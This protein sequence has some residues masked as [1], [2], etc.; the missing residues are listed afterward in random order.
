MS[1]V[2][3]ERVAAARASV[4]GTRRTRQRR[5]VVVSAVLVVLVAAAFVGSVLYGTRTVSLGEV[6]E[7][8]GGGGTRA[9]YYL[10]VELRL[11]RALTGLLVGLC[12]G[13]AGALFQTLLRNPL[14]SPDV[15]GI[16][17]GASAAAVVASVAFGLSGAAMS[18]S[19]LGGALLAATLIYLLA[20]RNGVSGQRL[21][22]VGI[23]VAA[24]LTSVVS[25]MM[26]RSSAVVAQEARIWL[27]GSLNGRTWEHVGPLLAA[28]VLLFPLTVAAARSLGTLQ[29]GDEAA[30]AL[31]TR[32]ERSR[33]ALIGCAVAL[34]GA[35][36]A[37]AGPVG[38][39]AFVS[40]PIARRLLGREAPAL[41]PSALIGALIVLVSDQVA[42]H[43]LGSNQFP[44]GMVTSIIGAPYLLWLLTR[45]NRKGRG[46]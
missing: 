44:V 32:V 21:V 10:V 3:T 18:L 19:A 38:F 37:A 2:V 40:G 35:A 43:A 23:G 5:E 45:A 42:Q 15:I 29:L 25:H 34:T 22:L 28:V 17:A 11:P 31:G 16:S 9:T 1:A 41:L 8:L 36:T 33:V 14:A 4:R 20:W 39:V 26:T 7:A 30:S 6:V 27:A 12:F 46:G 13:L 24:A